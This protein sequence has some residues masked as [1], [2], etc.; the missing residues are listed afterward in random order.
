MPNM[1]TMLCF[2]LSDIRIP[3]GDMEGILR[4]SAEATFN[5]ITVD[6]DTSTNDTALMMASGL[7]ENDPL[8][9]EDRAVFAE[10]LKSVLWDLSRMI[11]SDG[12]GA[13]KLVSVEVK[14]AFSLADAG[15][16]ART[17]ANSSLV[18]TAIYGQDPNW[19]RILAAL[20]RAD[21]EMKEERVGIW[22]DDVQIVSGG[23]GLGTEQESK[24]KEI[25]KGKE[26]K[27]V[28]DLGQGGFDDRILT[29]DLTHEY[30][31][32]NADYRT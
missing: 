17:V 2:V 14:N 16:A 11:V 18:K 4:T 9:E 3:A 31:S 6:G 7:A 8:T 27:L 20:G 1:A 29:C 23:L 13:T 32:I 25:M 24:A 22:I 12:E 19:G 26:F 15:A 21:I 30:V 10:G 28:I 5:R